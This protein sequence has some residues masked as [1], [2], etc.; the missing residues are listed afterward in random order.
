MAPSA[1]V[2][3]SGGAPNSPLMAGALAAIYEAGKTFNN[4]YTS[5]AGAVP[6][7]LFI[8]PRG[9]EGPAALE[10]SVGAAAISDEIYRWLPI[11]YKTFYKPGPFTVPMAR[12]AKAFKVPARPLDRQDGAQRLWND[13]V[14][15]WA[16]VLTPTWLT[17]LDRGICP[18]FPFT[19]EVID[20]DKL[21]AFQGTFQ[22]NAYNLD[23]HKIEEF[24][25]DSLDV[26]QFAAAFAFPFVYKPVSI[27]GVYYS[28]G[29][30]R[31]PLNLPGLHS[32][33]HRTL[34]PD[35]LSD[36][37]VVLLDVLG[38]MEDELVRVP[39]NLIDAY[40]IQIMT[41]VVSLAKI[42]KAEFLKEHGLQKDKDE[43]GYCFHEVRQKAA[44]GKTAG[45]YT[46]CEIPFEI[47]PAHR[48]YTTEWSF[49]NMSLLW[50]IGK[51]AGKRWVEQHHKLLPD[52][53][54]GGPSP[55]NPHP[56]FP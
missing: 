46:F 6:A 9:L 55:K 50:E 1:T 14:D 18:P 4:F 36:H 52:R 26:P 28:E 2:V 7:L 32:R 49:S 22:L 8:A 47:P 43:D 42:K 25:R 54:A 31:D 45:T 44:A 34:H 21:K 19:N 56:G 33:L 23:T 16:A 35:D 20:F 12:L 13:A 38:S 27:N 15:L 29:A 24:T 41:P 51:K 30:D 11:G 37:T 48:P 40:G 3:L 5:G 39:R 17:P 53:E 10:A